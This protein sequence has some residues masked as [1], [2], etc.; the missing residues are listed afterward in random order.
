MSK[1]T[2]PKCDNPEKVDA[3]LMKKWLIAGELLDRTW[4]VRSK[5]STSVAFGL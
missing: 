3:Y 5:P 4:K 2:C 1:A